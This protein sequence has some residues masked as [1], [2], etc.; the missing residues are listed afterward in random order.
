MTLDK[1]TLNKATLN[2]ALDDVCLEWDISGNFIVI[3][4]D[5]VLHDQVLG[6]CR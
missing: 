5:E 4:N 1:A 2:K 6:F 3:Q